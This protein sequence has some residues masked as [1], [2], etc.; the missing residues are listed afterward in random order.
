[1]G[2][3]KNIDSLK[4]DLFLGR[5]CSDTEPL[6]KPLTSFQ[7]YCN[8]TQRLGQ[9]HLA[10]SWI[11]TSTSFVTRIADSLTVVLCLISSTSPRTSIIWNQQQFNSVSRPGTQDH[12][13]ARKHELLKDD[14][15]IAQFCKKVCFIISKVHANKNYPNQLH[16]LSAKAPY[17]RNQ[18]TT[19]S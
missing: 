8:M 12:N 7:D 14:K 3:I 11:H 5:R 2:N 13:T 15:Q 6:A 1:M 16:L 4:L 10:L 19:H 18:P 17:D 9:H